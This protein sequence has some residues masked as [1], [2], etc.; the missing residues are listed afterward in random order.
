MP[1]ASLSA[2]PRKAHAQFMAG[3]PAS[4]PMDQ[5]REITCPCDAVRGT[6]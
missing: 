5:M 6:I 4:P 1:P 3:H 2:N